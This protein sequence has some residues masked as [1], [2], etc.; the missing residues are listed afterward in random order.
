MIS[1][2]VSFGYP[3]K[4]SYEIPNEYLSGWRNFS[5]KIIVI[6]PFSHMLRLFQDSFIFREATSSHFI[7]VTTSAHFPSNNFF[8]AAA[9]LRSSFFR[10][11]TSSQ[12]LLFQNTY[13]FRAK[14]LPS[15]YLLIKES[16]LG[17]LVF[18]TATFLAKELFRI[19]ISTE[20]LLFW[21][22][23][24]CIASTSSEDLHLGKS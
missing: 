21:S 1:S 4:Y 23:Y 13:F 19:K 16:S 6:K 3:D 18:G 10:T 14:L 5:G 17:Q 22:R 9:F 8:R 24:F 7:S 11:A 15:S 20:E 2:K 12:Q